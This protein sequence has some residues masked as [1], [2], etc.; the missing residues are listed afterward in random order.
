MRYFITG[1]I[2]FNGDEPF[3]IHCIAL[4]TGLASAHSEP[5]HPLCELHR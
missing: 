5:Q 1:K 2:G 4:T 3:S